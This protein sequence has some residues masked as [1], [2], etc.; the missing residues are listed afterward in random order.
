ME[1]FRPT[2]L[3]ELLLVLQRELLAWPPRLPEQ[4][5]FY[6]VLNLGYAMQIARDWNTRSDALVG[7]V[8][9]FEIDDAYASRFERRVVGGRQHEELWVPADELD[10]CNRHLQA[11]IRVV[12]AFFGADFQGLV[13]AGGAFRGRGAREQL[14]ILAA[15]YDYNLM[16]FHGEVT[17]NRDA[18]F[19]HLP[20]WQ[21]LDSSTLALAAPK[22]EVLAAVRRVWG[23][24]FPALPLPEVTS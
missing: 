11:P 1:L 20:F 9:R 10:E 15:Q 8:T 7:Y 16:D 22:D 18:V 5:I 17:M 4:P 19:L 6:P 14:R 23:D 13:P 21:Q 12:A 3:H 2:G 24:A